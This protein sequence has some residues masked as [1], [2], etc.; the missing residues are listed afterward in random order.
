MKK[1]SEPAQNE[2]TRSPKPSRRL[3]QAIYGDEAVELRASQ[4]LVTLTPRVGCG[5]ALVSATMAVALPVDYPRRSPAVAVERSRGLSD[6]GLS[7][8]HTAALTALEAYEGEECLCQ[9][10]A[11]VNEALDLIND[12]SE[13]LP[14][15][16]DLRDFQG[17]HMVFCRVSGPK[18]VETHRTSHKPCPEAI[19]MS[20]CSTVQRCQGSAWKPVVP[21]P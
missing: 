15:G 13:C 7:A 11:E 20:I 12:E 3:S 9:V 10:M 4:L 5:V 16:D 17:F 18:Q 6:R 14:R 19:G 2:V 1:G 8:L 21:P